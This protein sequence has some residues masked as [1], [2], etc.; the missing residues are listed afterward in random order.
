MPNEILDSNK[1]GPIDVMQGSVSA[2]QLDD[3]DTQQRAEWMDLNAKATTVR[4]L[5]RILVC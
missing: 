2:G 4:T 5:G 3:E 1:L